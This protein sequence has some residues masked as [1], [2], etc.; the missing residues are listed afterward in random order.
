[1]TVAEQIERL[2]SQ[3]PANR[4]HTAERIRKV[5]GLPPGTCEVVEQTENGKDVYLGEQVTAAPK[6]SHRTWKRTSPFDLHRAPSLADRAEAIC[7]A[8]GLRTE[9]VT[10]YTQKD[11]PAKTPTTP[12][13]QPA[14]TPRRHAAAALIGLQVTHPALYRAV[15]GA[16]LDVLTPTCPRPFAR[17]DSRGVIE[18]DRD[19]DYA[20][21]AAPDSWRFV[22]ADGSIWEH[23]PVLNRT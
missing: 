10:G 15:C 6:T 11:L 22:R 12:A 18:R 4:N 1:V 9:Q 13:V 23:M 3:T 8:I 17:L 2:D 20:V 14:P 5:V 21:S 19:T 16:L 7:R